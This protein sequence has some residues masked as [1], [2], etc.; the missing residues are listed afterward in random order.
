ML[1]FWEINDYFSILRK[2]GRSKGTGKVWMYACMLG[3]RK[4][5]TEFPPLHT[6]KKGNIYQS[7][8]KVIMDDTTRE[9]GLCF[10]IQKGAVP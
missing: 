9:Y 3:M 6:Q 2:R 1:A 5:K 10:T 7:Y 4:A 8:C